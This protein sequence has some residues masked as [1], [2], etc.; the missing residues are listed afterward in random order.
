MP[1]PTS[2]ESIQSDELGVSPLSLIRTQGDLKDYID[3]P[4]TS[5][6]HLKT[7]SDLIYLVR[8]LGI[9][10]NQI[11]VLTS[12]LKEWSFLIAETRTCLLS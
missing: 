5:T 8:D 10:K 3:K 6:P 2:P 1:I 4:F 12:R 9:S 7:K 11:E